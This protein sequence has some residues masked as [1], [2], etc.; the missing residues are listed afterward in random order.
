M[1]MK[2]LIPLK[3]PN[4]SGEEHLKHKWML[5]LMKICWPLLSRRT[6]LPMKRTIPS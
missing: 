6:I 3:A 1:G 5:I 4:R 2:T